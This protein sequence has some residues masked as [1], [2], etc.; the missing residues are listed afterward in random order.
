MDPCKVD[1]MLLCYMLCLNV[2][3]VVLLQVMCEKEW[4]SQIRSR[5]ISLYATGTVILLP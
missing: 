3:Y 2:F 5:T 4:I 1:Y